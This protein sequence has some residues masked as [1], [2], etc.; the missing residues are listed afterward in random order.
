M[1]W[2]TLHHGLRV[3]RFPEMLE[4]RQDY[5]K[6][7]V[8]TRV[9]LHRVALRRVALRR[10]ALRSAASRC[11]ALR[12]HCVA[13]CRVFGIVLGTMVASFLASFCAAYLGH[14]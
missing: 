9:A 1:W 12:S 8:C 10:V 5:I 14:I 6:N 3:L 7:R 13:R 4:I 11:V 2:A